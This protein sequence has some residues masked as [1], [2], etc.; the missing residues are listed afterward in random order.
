MKK[1]LSIIIEINQITVAYKD[2][3]NQSA[4]LKLDPTRIKKVLQNYQK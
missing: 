2:Q 1:I 3:Y 4:I